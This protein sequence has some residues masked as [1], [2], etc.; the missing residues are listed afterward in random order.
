MVATFLIVLLAL[1]SAYLIYRLVGGFRFYLKLRGKR[2]VTCPATNETVEVNM[3]AGTVAIEALVGPPRLRLNECSGWPDHK[4]CGQECLKQIEATPKD[5]MVRT[6]ISEWY[7]GRKCSYC[8]K[9]FGK[10]KWHDHKQA[11]MGADGRSFLWDEIP[12]ETLPEVLGTHQP[13]CWNCHTAE[14]F[15]REHPNLVTDQPRTG[16]PTKVKL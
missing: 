4:N 15:R 13:V 12:S 1:V 2:L 8:R 10:I 3:P 11:L 7:E 5:C 6:I 9:P 16:D 14:T